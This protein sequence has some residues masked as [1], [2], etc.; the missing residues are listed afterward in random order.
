MFSIIATD[1]EGTVDTDTLQRFLD[2]LKKQNFKDFEVLIMHDGPR[3]ISI[4]LNTD[5]LDVKFFESVFRGNVWGHNLRTCGMM[6]SS[7]EYLINTNTDNIYYPNALQE[8][9]DY[10]NT[11]GDEFKVFINH[12]KMMGLQLVEE[13][14]ILGDGNTLVQR[15]IKYDKPRDYTKSL[16]L[17]GDPPVFGNIDLMNLVA[18]KSIWKNIYYWFDLSVSSDAVIYQKICSLYNYTNTKILI[19]EHW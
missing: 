8:L 10:I 5:G 17:T 15:K 3:K 2:Y 16:I 11:Y 1:Y 14:I 4:N 12:V 9:S 13:K 18:H 19:G 6:E 7:G